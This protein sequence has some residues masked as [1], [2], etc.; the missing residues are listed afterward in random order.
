MSIMGH[1][2]SDKRTT[3]RCTQHQ[4]E[5]ESRSPVRHRR[6]DESGSFA[7]FVQLLVATHFKGANEAMHA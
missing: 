5:G 7:R 3:E 6:P 2:A 4:C 1:E